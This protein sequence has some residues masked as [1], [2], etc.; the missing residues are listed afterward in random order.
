MPTPRQL[1]SE[2]RVLSSQADLCMAQNMVERTGQNFGKDTIDQSL[3]D[4]GKYQ[5]LQLAHQDVTWIYNCGESEEDGFLAGLRALDF[6]SNFYDGV[7]GKVEPIIVPQPTFLAPKDIED[8]SSFVDYIF[9][10][11]KSKGLSH[12]IASV[13]VSDAVSP[14]AMAKRNFFL[15]NTVV[16]YLLKIPNGAGLA[17]NRAIR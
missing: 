16:I 3:V 6:Y 9:V 11:G 13:E 12:L 4:V 8:V 15:A 7:F 5:W 2:P 14:I 1:P 10:L 17:S